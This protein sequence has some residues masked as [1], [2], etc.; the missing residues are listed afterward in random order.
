MVMELEN[1]G[2]EE[3][4]ADEVKLQEAA[5]EVV[6]VPVVFGDMALVD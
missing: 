6:R 1:G 2:R 3:E 4:L 5:M